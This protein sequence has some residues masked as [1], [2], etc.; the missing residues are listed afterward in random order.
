MAFTLVR[1]FSHIVLKWLIPVRAGRC[2]T[3]GTG[4]ILDLL[5]QRGYRAKEMSPQRIFAAL[6][7]RYGRVTKNGRSLHA[8]FA[9]KFSPTS[10]SAALQVL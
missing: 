7:R 2:R 6:G 5:R 3:T 1:R 4:A 9:F 8:R 10:F